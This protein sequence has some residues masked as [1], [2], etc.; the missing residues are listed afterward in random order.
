MELEE[1]IMAVE[2]CKWSTHLVPGA[3][4]VT[5]SKVMDEYGCRYVVHGDDITTDANGNDCYRQVK[6][7]DRF[8]VVK[9]TP[10]I[11]TTDLVGRMLSLSKSHHLK[12]LTKELIQ[13]FDMGLERFKR[14]ASGPDGLSA[15]A[16]VF[17]VN[18][19]SLINIVDSSKELET[20][21]LN[22]SYYV[23]GG[24]DL[25]F[26]GHIKL[27]KRV[28]Q[29]A[30]DDHP[31]IVGIHDDETMNRAKGSN[32]PIMN[33]YQRALCVLQCKYV[34]GVILNAP[35]TIT[36]QYL[37][38]LNIDGKLNVVKVLHGP[39]QTIEQYQVAKELGVFEQIEPHEYDSMTTNT[40]VDRVLTN[41]Q[42][43][44]ERQRKKGWKS[45]NEKKLEIL[46]KQ[47][48]EIKSVV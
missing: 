43:Y 7:M 29:H 24:F 16:S 33:Q 20:K 45:E 27:L 35:F 4:Y 5:D 15:G 47:Q 6:E 46:E 28:R 12:Q 17:A 14:Y 8:V 2:A 10:E 48:N 41:R 1:R 32:F 44:E 42:L 9:R 38:Q 3:P 30:G 22:G 25:F 23:D 18:D 40:I 19:N 34:D 37:K 36:K 21:L 26:V 13:T 31:I 39:T 11:S